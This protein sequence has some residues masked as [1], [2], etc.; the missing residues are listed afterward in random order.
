MG[1]TLRWTLLLL[2]LTACGPDAKT[3]K[4]QR[5]RDRIVDVHAAIREI[6][7]GGELLVGPYASL[8]T[9]G[10]YLLILDPRSYDE[11]LHVLDRHTFRPLRSGIK[12]GRGPG[13]VVIPGDLWIDEERGR[14]YCPDYGTYRVY[15]YD[16]E[17]FM[18][19]SDY[20]PEET[21]TM[22]KGRFPASSCFIGEGR[23]LGVTIE[24]VGNNS[25]RQALA[26]WD[27]ETGRIDPMPYE[28]P[29]IERRRINFAVSVAHDLYAEVYRHHDL[30]TLGSLD[31]TLKCNIYGPRWDPATQ[32]RLQF[33][34][35]AVFCGDRFVVT[36][37]GGSEWTRDGGATRLMLFDLEGEYLKTF[38]TGYKIS[39]LCYDERENRL[40]LCLDDVMQFA[41][42][43]LDGLL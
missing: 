22:E 36:Y 23:L 12:K 15:R 27:L 3:E 8:Y 31:G 42:L 1:N 33:F 39:G 7:P 21:T 17:R 2:L 34:G 13:E 41:C 9:M 38:E 18:A 16:M 32:N 25:F 20:L 28:H 11:L 43:E 10:D 30:I 24:P 35:D 6:D 26:R 19:D 40:I 29:Q 4:H 14:F 37:G 5:R